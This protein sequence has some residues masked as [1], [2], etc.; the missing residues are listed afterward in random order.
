MSFISSLDPDKIS[1]VEFD[2]KSLHPPTSQRPSRPFYGCRFLR[3]GCFLCH[4]WFSPG[5]LALGL[6][7]FRAAPVGTAG[8]ARCG[9]RGSGLATHQARI[10]DCFNLVS[11]AVLVRFSIH[12]LAAL[13]S[14]IFRLLGRFYG[15]PLARAVQ[16][17]A[18]RMLDVRGTDS[19]HR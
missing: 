16:L 11:T 13:R 2:Y 18:L 4:E 10:N 17:R 9:I 12:A 8:K 5:G 19:E 14:P 3:F 15:F 6:T 7:T 1:V